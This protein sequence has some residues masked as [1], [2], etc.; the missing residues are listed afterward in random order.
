MAL[1]IQ[2]STQQSSAI[3]VRAYYSILSICSFLLFYIDGAILDWTI[4]KLLRFS[5][6]CDTGYIEIS[7]KELDIELERPST[8]AKL[9][10]Q[11]SK[12]CKRLISGKSFKSRKK[13]IARYHQLEDCPLDKISDTRENMSPRILSQN[14]PL[15]QMLTI[16]FMF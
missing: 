8:T 11:I 14:F 5:E 3:Q 4:V 16:V 15:W 12:V 1:L 13:A 2:P 7:E 6:E 10:M 9:C